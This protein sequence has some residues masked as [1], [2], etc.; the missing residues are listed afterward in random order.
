MSTLGAFGFHTQKHAE[1]QQHVQ[2]QQQQQ[3]QKQLKNNRLTT[4]RNTTH[5][6]IASTSSSS[7]NVPS[8]ITCVPWLLSPTTDS[9]SKSS[10]VTMDKNQNQTLKTI[11]PS[12]TM[13]TRKHKTSKGKTTTKKTSGS[14]TITQFFAPQKQSTNIAMEIDE[15]GKQQAVVR[16]QI[17]FEELWQRLVKEYSNN[18]NDSQQDNDNNNNNKSFK[19]IN[20]RRKH[21]DDDEEQNECCA[22]VPRQ[23]NKK[24]KFTVD[25]EFLLKFQQLLTV[26]NPSLYNIPLVLDDNDDKGQEEQTVIVT[27]RRQ[28]TVNESMELFNQIANELLLL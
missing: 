6:P 5:T 16:K 18:N 19:C 22:V 17:S 9:P 7:T 15:K 11:M 3:Q 28:L 20:R 26:N 2:K 23:A 27:I 13:S 1:Q 14:T 10:F 21:D 25:H 24:T 8:Q 12:N 4:F